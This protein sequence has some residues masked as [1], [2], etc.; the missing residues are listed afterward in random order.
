MHISNVIEKGVEFASSSQAHFLSNPPEEQKQST[1]QQYKHALTYFVLFVLNTGLI[2]DIPRAIE[3]LARA[4]N[5]PLS[6]Y[7]I[8]IQNKSLRKDDLDASVLE[9]KCKF[10]FERGNR[11]FLRVFEYSDLGFQTSGLNE[12]ITKLTERIPFEIEQYF[13]TV[14]AQSR[15][16]HI[17]QNQLRKGLDLVREVMRQKEHFLDSVDIYT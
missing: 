1:P 3:Q 10:L 11:K 16:F 6:V 12:V 9:Q 14:A 15:N 2:D 17:E 7:V 13:D 4:I 8:N 5:M